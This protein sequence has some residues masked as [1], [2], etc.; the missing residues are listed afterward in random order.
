[1]RALARKS[2][3]AVLLALCATASPGAEPDT[4]CDRAC[5][6]SLA[7]RLLDAMVARDVSALPLARPYAATENAAAAALPMM[8]AWRTVTEAP[9]DRRFYVIDPR[10]GQ[11]FVVAGLK[12]GATDTLLWGRFKVQARQFAE[13]ELHLNRSRGQGGYQLGGAGP[14]NFPSAWTRPVPQAQRATRAEL[15][16]HARSIFD[17]RWPNLPPAPTCALMEN[18]Q[19]VQEHAEVAAEVA[20]AA[21]APRDAQGF[22]AI[23]CGM[24][25]PRPTD[26][27]ARTGIVDEEQGIVVAQ[28]TVHGSTQPM[29]LTSPT[30]S[31]FVPDQI[32]APYAAMLRKQQASGRFTAAAVRALPATASVAE[33]HRVF[34]GRIQG[35]LLLVHLGAPG[36]RSPWSR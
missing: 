26:P 30:E 28:A 34:D 15:A 14:L 9:I 29:L 5:L 31:A 1:M 36:G 16:R 32:L 35:Q 8:A 17:V 18:G 4:A 21:N 2:G 20:G 10:S 7:D 25:R 22:V 11:V 3:L 6:R 23:P 24:P 27:R 33:V 12:E 19:V 13:I